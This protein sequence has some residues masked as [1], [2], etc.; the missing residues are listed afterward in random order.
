M[1]RRIRSLRPD[2][3]MV[4]VPIGGELDSNERERLK[5]HDVLTKPFYLP[6]LAQKMDAALGLPAA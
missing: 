2:L 5:I 6:D 1:L 3:I 4:A